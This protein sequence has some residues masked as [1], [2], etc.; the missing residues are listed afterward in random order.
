MLV[1]AELTVCGISS[2]DN[3]AVDIRL[4][5]NSASDDDT[6]AAM[7]AVV[8]GRM[9]LRW[10][11]GRPVVV[12]SESPMIISVTDCERND[13]S[14]LCC[15]T[16]SAWVVDSMA[17][18][19]SVFSCGP[20]PVSFVVSV[21][22][23]VS[24]IIFCVVSDTDCLAPLSFCVIASPAVTV[25]VDFRATDDADVM[26]TMSSVCCSVVVCSKIV[27]SCRSADR[28]L[29]RSVVLCGASSAADEV[30]SVFDVLTSRVAVD[31]GLV[32][33]DSVEKIGVS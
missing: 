33:H 19:L 22:N 3:G 14:P 17:Y 25:G 21:T 18:S 4:L 28:D 23:G 7:D 31:K 6:A 2:A 27:S 30:I 10:R 5:S 24:R 20:P 8:I 15:C 12:G 13:T 26:N 32:D 29:P 11:V 1:E 16:T 9:R